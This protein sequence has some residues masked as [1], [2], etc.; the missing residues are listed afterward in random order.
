MPDDLEQ[1]GRDIQA[2]VRQWVNIP[3]GVGIGP[4]KTL[5]KLAQWAGKNWPATGGVVNLM[6]RQRQQ[7]LL[8]LTPVG[9]VWGVGRKLSSQLETLGIKTAFDLASAD[10]RRIG[11]MFSKVLERTARELRGEQWLKIHD[12]PDPKKEI[13]SSKMFGRRVYRLEELRQAAAAYTTRAAEKLRGQ[14]S[15]CSELLVSVQTGQ[16]AD[17]ADR[18]WNGARMPLPTPTADTRELIMAA[19]QGLLEIY[20]PGFAYSKCTIQLCRLSQMEG[21]T[22]DMFAPQPRRNADQLMATM[23][24]INERFGRGALRVATIPSAPGWM[25][26]RELLSPSYTTRWQDLPRAR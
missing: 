25:M 18:Y 15:V 2:R 20:R 26:R 21:L 16:F 22:G 12:D 11:G 4:T 10:P 1:L 24:M 19:S 17:P 7:K 3:V 23:D 5:A 8:R 6:D 9:E 14:G 13:V